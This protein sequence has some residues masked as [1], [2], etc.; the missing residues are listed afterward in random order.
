MA[1]T[2]QPFNLCQKAFLLAWESNRVGDTPGDASTLAQT[3][4]NKLTTYLGLPDVQKAM[5]GQWSLAWGPAVFQSGT[6]HAANVL[7][8]AD[9]VMYVAAS[10]D[11]SVYVVAIAGTNGS[12]TYDVDAEDNT[13]N[14]TKLWVDAFPALKPYGDYS[15][16]LDINPWPTLSAGTALG[17]NNL[18]SMT[19]ELTTQKNLVDFLKS[20][21]DTGSKT[22]IFSGHSLGGALAPTLALAL[23]NPSGGPLSIKSWGHV[24][25]LPVAGPTPGNQGLS[26]FFGQVFPQDS[27]NLSQPQYA[28]N[29][30]IWNTLD[31]VPHVW[32]VDMIKEIPTLYPKNTNWDGGEVPSDIT[33]LVNTAVL[34]S[35]AGGLLPGPYTQLPNIP[36]TGTFHGPDPVHDDGTFFAEVG[37]QHLDA[38]QILFG[39]QDLVSEGAQLAL[40]QMLKRWLDSVPRMAA[41][42]RGAAVR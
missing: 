8:F 14:T 32:V 18:L 41:E 5:E 21:S 12:S 26:Q 6:K 20:L 40:Q 3:L 37:Y 28:W 33:N 9:N 24:Y 30:N 7:R 16:P 13:V 10:P 11:Q 17:A 1:S 35:Q 4:Q 22:L 39:I 2:I 27:L 42:S 34:A 38:Y 25:V 19:D 29:R 36:V 23:F 31:L 15:A